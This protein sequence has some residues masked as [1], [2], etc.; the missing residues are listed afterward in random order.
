M[1]ADKVSENTYRVRKQYK[2]KQYTVYFDHK[3]ND[4]EVLNA[5][6]EKLDEPEFGTNNGSFELFAKKYIDTKRNVLSESTA[7]GYQKI[8][9]ALSKEF[10]EKKLYDIDIQDVQAEVNRYAKGR[11]PKSVKNFHGFISAVLKLYRPRFNST[12]K[13]PQKKKYN[14]Y[15]PSEEEVKLILD[16]SKGT[17]YHIG[18]QLAVLGMRRSEISAVTID[19]L[20]GNLL[21]INKDRIYD[22]E[23]HLITRDN[24][25]TE[26][27]T[28]EIYI[29][30]AL[31]EEI[32]KAGVIYDRTPPMLV[33]TLHKYQ[34]SLGIPRFRLHDLR[35]FFVSYAHSIGIPDLYIQKA[36]GWKSDFIM[37]NTYLKELQ[38]KSHEAQKNISANLIGQ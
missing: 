1:K 19:D 2:G 15:T 18:F 23:N 28:R 37:K 38:D 20:H 25:K 12:V 4:R 24:T 17:P 7:G 29:P 30:D 3:P 32:H 27:S 14:G 6:T 13:V 35:V 33:K 16:A 10:K 8:I 26:E 9:R 22:E 11:A 21:S 5:I 31:V 36:G 34:D